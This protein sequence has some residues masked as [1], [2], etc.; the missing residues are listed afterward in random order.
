M[1]RFTQRIGLATGTAVF[2]GILLMGI[3]IFRLNETSMGTGM[4]LSLVH[5]ALG[6]G[7]FVG[8]I[9]SLVLRMKGDKTE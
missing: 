7:F 8:F 5:A 3:W 2:L 6:L 1:T 4:I 9:M